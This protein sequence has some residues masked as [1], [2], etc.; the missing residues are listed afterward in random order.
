MLGVQWSHIFTWDL[1][2]DGVKYKL[3]GT[4]GPVI[5]TGNTGTPEDRCAG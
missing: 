1:K 4:H 2:L 5:V 3:A